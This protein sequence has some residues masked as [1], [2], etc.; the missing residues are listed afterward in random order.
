MIRFARTC[1]ISLALVMGG[2]A[3]AQGPITIDDLEMMS[4]DELDELYLNSE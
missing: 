3:L 2:V 4:Q 1:F